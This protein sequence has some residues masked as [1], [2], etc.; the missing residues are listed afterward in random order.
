[1]LK[2]TNCRLCLSIQRKR[3]ASIYVQEVL[4][5]LGM[6]QSSWVNTFLATLFE[7]TKLAAMVQ[8]DEESH[9]KKHS[10]NFGEVSEDPH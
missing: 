1:M 10:N 3:L 6:E 9:P 8:S 7:K 5:S 4:D 2:K